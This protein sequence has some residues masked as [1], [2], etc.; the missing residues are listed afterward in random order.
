MHYLIQ[1]RGPGNG[2]VFR[3]VTP[4]ELVGI[5]NPWDGKPLGREVRRG[6]GTRHLPEAR[7]RRDIALGDVRKLQNGLTDEARWS[8]QS[9]LDWRE[10]AETLRQ[11]DEEAAEDLDLIFP[12]LLE[13]AERKGVPIQTL[14]RFARV[15]S[16]KGFPL[17][18]ALERYKEDRRAGNQRGYQP[19]ART[20]V[21]NLHT[22]V[23]HLRAF[24]RDDGSTACLEDVTPD[25][26]IRFRDDYLPAVETGRGTGLMS[27]QTIAKNLT[28]LRGLW[29]WAGERRLVS[30]PYTNPWNFARG[31]IR[32]AKNTGQPKREDYQPSEASRLLKATTAGTRE[33]DVIRLALVTGCRADEIASLSASAVQPD[34]SGF[35]IGHGKTE[36]ARRFVPVVGDAQTLLQARLSSHG[37]SGSPLPRVAPQTRR[38]EGLCGLAV[39]HPVPAGDAWQGER[40]SA[41]A[42]LDAPHMEDRRPPCPRQRGRCERAWWLGGS[43]FFQCS[44]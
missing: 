12:D 29:V 32:R 44:I 41:L 27:A 17:S 40:R 3:M 30:P 43:A 10:S 38:G 4:R 14:R 28:L 18:L 8:L 2:W 7:K 1:P 15:A 9:A 37:A 31:M 20:T 33:G 35:T 34:G 25:E 22:A 42:T 6:L 26:A 21:L 19:L 36:N 11:K 39:V 13:Q 5:P 16:G 24:L 23:K